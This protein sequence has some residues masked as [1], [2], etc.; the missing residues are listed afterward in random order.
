MSPN[1]KS[2]VYCTGVESGGEEEW[3]AVWNQYLIS[4]VATERSQM[5]SALGCSK[6]IWILSRWV[7]SGQLCILNLVLQLPFMSYK[8]CLLYVLLKI[9]TDLLVC[10][11]LEVNYIFTQVS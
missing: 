11:N 9:F 8:V 6:Y 2:T 7:C 3:E 4:N 1:L 5:L 10:T